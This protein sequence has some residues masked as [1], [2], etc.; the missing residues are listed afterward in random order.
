MLGAMLDTDAKALVHE[1]GALGRRG[2]DS[3]TIFALLGAAVALSLSPAAAP[4]VW[5]SAVL[6]WEW[7]VTPLA[8]NVLARHRDNP[9]RD[10]AAQI[11]LTGAGAALYALYPFLLFPQYGVLG[12]MLAVAWLAGSTTHA[13]TYLAVHPRLLAAGLAPI[14]VAGFVLPWLYWGWDWHAALVVFG[15]ISLVAVT[16][17]YAIES[18][19]FL[20]NV[21]KA[22]HRRA[23][24]AVAERT[25]TDMLAVVSHELRTPV[26]AIEGYA[27]LLA[28][29]AADGNARSEDIEK[30][31]QASARLRRLVQRAIDIMHL[32]AGNATL[33]LTEV[34]IGALVGETAS[35]WRGPALTRNNRLLTV[36][37]DDHRLTLDSD[38]VRLC[39][40][41]LLENA[42]KFTQDGTVSLTVRA[43]AAQVIFVVEDDGEGIP[44]EALLYI[45]RPFRQADMKSGRA[46]EGA[47][48]GLALADRLASAMG[49]DLTIAALPVKGTGATLRLPRADP[50]AA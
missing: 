14:I 16:V 20:D 21:N 44:E 15:I 19:R 36:V 1:A 2:W 48:L 47:G 24:D 30:I 28:T 43:D 10:L 3:R 34:Q 8:V 32:D 49:G 23:A 27:E 18:A 13:T 33:T 17:I 39:L 11:A 31:R 7:G 12:G 42:I 4:L 26:S 6:F 5:L 37:D 40:E 46:H 45:K 9:D 25:S 29:E 38:K 50:S 35:Q 41:C 22:T